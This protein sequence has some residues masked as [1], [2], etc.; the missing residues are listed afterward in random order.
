MRVFNRP[1]RIPGI[2]AHAHKVLA[3]F[4]D[5]PLQF[6]RLHVAGMILDGDLEPAVHNPRPHGS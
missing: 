6:A 4:L 3:G 1:Q 5:Q 2:Q